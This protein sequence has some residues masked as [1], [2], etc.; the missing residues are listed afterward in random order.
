MF[1]IEAC[2][3][4][5]ITFIRQPCANS[6]FEQHNGDICCCLNISGIEAVPLYVVMSNSLQFNSR[7]GVTCASSAAVACS[8]PL[9]AEIG[10]RERFTALFSYYLSVSIK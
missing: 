5:E 9:A 10:H 4:L 6:E 3:F 2:F 8:Q 1:L 7:R